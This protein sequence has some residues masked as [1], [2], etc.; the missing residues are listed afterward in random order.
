MMSGSEEEFDVWLREI[1]DRLDTAAAGSIDVDAEL[2]KVQ[3][4]S[5]DGRLTQDVAGSSPVTCTSAGGLHQTIF[6]V[7]IAG[8][9]GMGRSRANYVAL[10]AG[11]YEAVE[12]AFAEAGIPWDECFQQD[13]GDSILALAPPTVPKGAFVGTLPRALAAALAAHNA[14]HPPEERIKLRL[15]LHAGEVTFDRWGVAAPAVIH[16]CRLLSA[17]PLKDALASSPGTLAMI[18]SDWFYSEVVRHS[19]EY[20]PH[21]YRRVRVN[22]K[23]M[24]GV[25]WI[26]LPDH[27]L[28]AYGPVVASPVVV[29]AEPPVLGSLLRPASPEFYEVVDALEE[30]PCMQGEHSRNLVIDQLRFAGTIR[31]FPSRR[32]HVTSILRTCLDFEGGVLQLVTIIASQEPSGSIPLKRLLSMLTD[33]AL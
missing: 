3:Q 1:S 28:P 26:R 25:G 19:A 11:M 9:G 20:E 6:T 12:E 27:E 24:T 33:G 22:V 21:T 14:T 15:S 10:R 29:A 7:D 32:A 23:E 30:I 31:Y 5:A 16:A 18:T 17:P 2:K 13:V 4:R 8:Y